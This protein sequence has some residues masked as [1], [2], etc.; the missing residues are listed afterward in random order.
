MVK[1]VE[2]V[3]LSTAGEGGVFDADAVSMACETA[4]TTCVNY[5][6]ADMSAEELSDMLSGPGM[7]V[8]A[9]PGVMGG[10]TEVVACLVHHSAMGKNFDVDP[11]IDACGSDG[12]K[13]VA[14]DTDGI[15]AYAVA[16][17]GPGNVVCS[18]D[19]TCDGCAGHDPAE[20]TV[21]LGGR[22]GGGG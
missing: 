7:G 16:V 19:V 6:S 3:S 20:A 18:S 13:E 11:P 15:K 14:V 22:A 12:R 1:K 9:T 17:Y 4:C 5:A 10:A 8:G 21:R 2:R